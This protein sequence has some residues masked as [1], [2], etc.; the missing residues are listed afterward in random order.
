MMS[1]L[2][3]LWPELLLTVVACVLF[4]IGSIPT[5]AA[6]RTVPIISL[7]ALLTVFAGLFWAGSNR[8]QYEDAGHTV[9]VDQISLYIKL[10]TSAVAVMFVLLSWPTNVCA[11]GQCRPGCQHRG[12]RVFCPDVARLGG[13]LPGRQRQ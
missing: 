13:N 8:A 5:A 10:L 6:R 9:F 1:L 7:L 11:N 3:P 4:L 2:Y 12:R